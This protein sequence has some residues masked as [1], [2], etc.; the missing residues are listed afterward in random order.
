MKRYTELIIAVTL[1][2]I[3]AAC[4]S[5]ASRDGERPAADRSF[6][7]GGRL[8]PGD[9]SAPIEEATFIVEN[10]KITSIGG[11]GELSP[12][13]GSAR[14]DITGQTIIP[15]LVNLH[16][17]PGLASGVPYSRE[18]VAADINRYTYYGVPTVVAIAADASDTAIQIR[19]EY[20]QNPAS[21]ARVFSTG[22]AIAA[23][24][25][26][27]TEGETPIQVAS[28]AEARNA[29][30]QLAGKKVDFV[31]MWIDDSMGRTAKL[32]PEIYR[33]VIDEAHK[34]NLRVFAHVFYLA[35]AKDLVTSGVDGLINSIRDREVDDQLISMMKE[36]NV[37]I[38]PTLT[39]H[40]AKYVY[41]DKPDWLGEQFMREAYPAQ[42]SAYLGD[43]VVVNRMNRNADLQQLK[44]HYST[45][46]ANLKKLADGGVR[47]GFGTGS[48]AP[49]TYP[50][51]FEHRELR[52]MASAGMSPAD[53]IKSA[54]SVSA[55]ILGIEEI[56]TIAVGK[57]ADFIALS[58]NPLDD[59]SNSQEIV[60]IYRNGHETD[61]LAL[62]QNLTVEVPRITAEDRTADR[63]AEARAAQER[64][65]A[66]LE[67]F[68]RFPLGPAVNLR[69]VAI[70]TPK[71]STARLTPGTPD[72]I[73]VAIRAT[74]N[75]FRG[76]Y[77]AALP[78]YRWQVQGSCWERTSPISNRVQ[79]LCLEPTA[80]NAVIQITER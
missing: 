58:S 23:R 15:V 30:T 20:R 7:F 71:G 46:A 21:L 57:N 33:A 3:L 44:Q 47:I 60:T 5:E 48:G 18:S 50:G 8:I 75:D 10:G 41:G 16:A 35:D 64:A 51:Y 74:A 72:R 78:R 19:D 4:S 24:G 45:A 79:V 31:R 37:F 13:E 55:N 9:G 63:A 54:T 17:H 22:Q 70:P 73:A 42:L 66:L 25:F 49:F 1:F 69:G 27:S 61:R 39:A 32:R 28:E 12:P 76:F 43:S 65:D 68:G 52:L 2:S 56:G 38:A 6:F 40:E 77:T 14:M 36:R 59:I 67:H 26:P 34:N 29:V 62:I 11:K 53:I 80:N